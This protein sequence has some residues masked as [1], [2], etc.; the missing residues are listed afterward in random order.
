[1]LRAA[2]TG[3]MLATTSSWALAQAAA[4]E[5]A[6][7]KPDDAITKLEKSPWLLVPTLQSNPKI[8]T[9]LGAM[10]GYLHYFDEKSR[11]SI[12]AVSGQVTSTDSTVAGGFARTSFDEDRQRLT[13]GLLYGYI[14]NDYSD[15]LGS[16]V[17]L[18]SNTELKSF[19]ARYQF[20]VKDTNWF[21]GGQA[22]YQNFAIFGETEF[23]QHIMDVVGI[24]PYKSGGVGLVAQYDS[25]D[26]ENMPTQG[27][28][29]TLFNVAYREQLGGDANF[30]IYRLEFRYY[31]PHGDRNV[32]AIRQMNHLT[33]DAPTQV[34]A[35]VMLRGYKVGQYNGDYMSSIE[36]EERFRLAEKWTATIFAGI[37][38]T[39]GGGKDCSDRA[40]LYPAGGVG[41]QYI[42]KP[43]E[44][45]VL[46]GEY[47][48]GKDGSYGFYLKMGY[49]Y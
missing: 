46:N 2:V 39:Y 25:R 32:F 26:N 10:G 35:P 1:M 36:G 27:W 42:L 9:S 22:V 6:L 11:P 15:Y 14:K 7:S 13:A 47:A 12:F 44:G 19:V 5:A 24:Q 33:S 3:L 34:K 45:I 37:A 4:Q 40:N 41:L 23:D 48:L 8:G 20:R 17:P 43:K 21:L 28:L 30:D 49:A 38:C 18:Q 29:A 16:G 31:I